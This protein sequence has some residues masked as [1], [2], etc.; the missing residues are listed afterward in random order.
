MQ[1]KVRIT[2]KERYR[3]SKKV[4]IV[5]MVVNTLLAIVKMVIGFF[6]RSPALF[7]DGVHSLSDLLSDV[8]VL[9]AAKYASK[10]EDEDHPYGHERI[11]TL[12]TM[13]LAAVLIAIGLSIGYHAVSGWITGNYE[14]PDQWTIYAAVFSI[15]ANE[16][17]FRY[18]MIV[19][20]RVNS[21]LLRANAWHSRS[22]M[23]SSVIVLIGLI[24]AMIGFPWMDAIAAIIV[25]F[26]I[27]K[28]GVKWGYRSI[29]ELIDEGVNPELLTEMNQIIASTEGVISHHA[30]RTRKM[31]G[32]I[33]VD[34][35]ILVEQHI[36]ASEGHYVGERVRGGLAK[37]IDD[38]KDIIVHID[39]A[40]HPER[41]ADPDKMPPC[42]SEI[43]QQMKQHLAEKSVDDAI[44]ENEMLL[45]YH[46]KKI[47]VVLFCFKSELPQVY[48]D[49][50]IDFSIEGVVETKV[51]VFGR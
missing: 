11:E 35:H 30:L 37:K 43:K 47:E 50:F 19:A 17:L 48:Q 46:H 8:M 27:V 23:W 7:A 10:E 28:M 49:A 29:N 32:K 3:Q 20:N 33:L 5:G 9:V 4:T 38:I 14:V 51:Y 25:C 45:Y 1:N 44:I 15:V 36:T 26:M 34:V 31:A 22:D 24:G 6:G 40:D 13:V 12:A 39:V 21:D 41:F 16:W 2:E 18:T 42:R